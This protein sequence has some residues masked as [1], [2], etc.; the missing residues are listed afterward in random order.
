MVRGHGAPEPA[1][2]LWRGGTCV[3]NVGVE[4]NGSLSDLLSVLFRECC[5]IAQGVKCGLLTVEAR[6]ECH[7][8]LN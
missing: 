3:S 5:V 6:G 1:W 2:T 7:V 8:T 4:E